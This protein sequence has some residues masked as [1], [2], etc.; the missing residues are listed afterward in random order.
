MPIQRHFANSHYAEMVDV[1]KGNTVN[2]DYI[3]KFG[4]NS[5][6]G[7]S[8]ETVWDGNNVYTYIDTAGTAEATAANS[9]DNNSIVEVSGL[10][11]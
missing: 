1:S 3:D 9:L 8:F 6:V 2:T 4:Y 7:N 11:V 5:A 10:D